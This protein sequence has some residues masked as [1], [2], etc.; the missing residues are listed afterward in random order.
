[1]LSRH[2]HRRQN[3]IRLA[4]TSC[5][6]PTMNCASGM[7]RAARR[8]SQFDFGIQRQQRRHAIRRRGRVAQVP[9][10]GAAILDLH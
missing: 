4:A 2:Q 9:R 5:D 1:M 3:F 10:H 6:C 8:R 7:R